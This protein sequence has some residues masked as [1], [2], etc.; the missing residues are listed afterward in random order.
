[1]LMFPLVSFSNI[2]NIAFGCSPTGL[3]ASKFF[4]F[5]HQITFLF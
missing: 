2:E 3:F 4:E 1:M 5:I